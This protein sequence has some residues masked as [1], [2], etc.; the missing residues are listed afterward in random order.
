MT[1]IHVV[2][3]SVIVGLRLDGPNLNVDFDI[4]I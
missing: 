2:N 1:H 4:L 3:M